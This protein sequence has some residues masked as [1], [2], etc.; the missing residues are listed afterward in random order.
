MHIRRTP[1]DKTRVSIGV[2]FQL[3]SRTFIYSHILRSHNPSQRL[4]APIAWAVVRTVFS[5]LSRM[6]P[7]VSVRH[8]FAVTGYSVFSLLP[9]NTRVLEISIDVWIAAVVSQKSHESFMGETADRKESPTLLPNRNVESA[10]KWLWKYRIRRMLTNLGPCTELCSE[11][12]I[13]YEYT[14]IS[15]SGEVF[16]LHASSR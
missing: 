15:P 7:F 14:S 9:V 16:V 3:Y 1:D 11:N 8:T 13:G 12:H 5:S 4:V 10:S 2:T 6:E